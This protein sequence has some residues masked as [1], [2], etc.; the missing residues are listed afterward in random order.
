MSLS[1]KL[2]DVMAI[3]PNEISF[4]SFKQKRVLWSGIER[5]PKKPATTTTFRLLARAIACSAKN[6]CLPRLSADLSGSS[7]W[8]RASVSLSWRETR[9]IWSTWPFVRCCHRIFAFPRTATS[10]C[11]LFRTNCRRAA[12]GKGAAFWAGPGLRSRDSCETKSQK[13]VQVH[14]RIIHLI[15]NGVEFKYCSGWL[16]SNFSL[17]D[18]SNRPHVGSR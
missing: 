9:S 17:A 18:D 6:H 4:V 13:S 12:P 11:N 1:E 2:E 14:A 5:L 15:N 16:V 3:L 10:W 7:L 8:P